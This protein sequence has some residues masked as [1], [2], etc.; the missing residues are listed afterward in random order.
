M[1][2]IENDEKT[3]VLLLYCLRAIT[4]KVIIDL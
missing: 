4:L 2:I 1:V 3:I